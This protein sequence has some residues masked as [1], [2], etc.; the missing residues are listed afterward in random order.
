MAEKK[1]TIKVK[2]EKKPILKIWFSNVKE[3]WFRL[4]KEERNDIQRKRAEKFRELGG[5]L[6]VSGTPYWSNEEWATFGVE[7]FPDI[8]AVQEYAEFIIELGWLRYNESKT[9]LCTRGSYEVS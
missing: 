6:L 9:Y 8:E 1:P 5:K 3:A 2:I 4:S 7:E